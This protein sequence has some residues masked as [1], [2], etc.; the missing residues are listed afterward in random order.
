[1]PD[2]VKTIHGIDGLDRSTP[3]GLLLSS[4]SQWIVV[5]G[6]ST[7][8][9][10]LT[11]ASTPSLVESIRDRIPEKSIPKKDGS[12]TSNRAPDLPMM[13][14]TSVLR[15]LVFTE[16]TTIPSRAAAHRSSTYGTPFGSHTATRSPGLIPH[17]S[18]PPQIRST[19][20]WICCEEVFWSSS[21]WHTMTRL[22]R[23]N[24]SGRLNRSRFSVSIRPRLED[25]DTVTKCV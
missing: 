7:V 13:S 23:E 8:P 10:R 19:S 6:P 16:T 11:T 14:S 17:F 9:P 21:S 1:M 25:P 22:I 18:R 15:N 2:V 12:T 5:Q 24:R 4:S 20:P 3:E